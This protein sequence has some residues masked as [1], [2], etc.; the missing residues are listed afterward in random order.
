MAKTKE[1][2]IME[3]YLEEKRYQK[4][5]EERR[6]AIKTRAMSYYRAILKI[7]DND[8]DLAINTLQNRANNNDFS[9]SALEESALM[10]AIEQLQYDRDT[11]YKE[12][13]LNRPL[14]KK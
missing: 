2:V 1:Q 11:T 7:T 13:S 10:I 5:K 12:V 4:E 8:Y 3:K 6:Q 9:D 14:L